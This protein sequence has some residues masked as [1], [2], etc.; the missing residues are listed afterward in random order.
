MSSTVLLLTWSRPAAGRARASLAHLD[1]FRRYLS[2]LVAGDRIGSY[3]MVLVDDRPRHLRGLFLIQGA[4]DKL[5]ELA[6]S[7]DWLDHMQRAAEHLDGVGPVWATTEQLMLREVAVPA[8]RVS[9]PFS[10]AEASSGG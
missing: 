4:R 2:G 8:N 3:E 5:N 10:L 6:R 7:A 9:G 1:S